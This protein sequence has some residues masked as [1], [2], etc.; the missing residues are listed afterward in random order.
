MILIYFT[1]FQAYRHTSRGT[2][3]SETMAGSR[4]SGQGA[5][6]MKA[7]LWIAWIAVLI[8]LGWNIL[9]PLS[10]DDD[11]TDQEEL[12]P[13]EAPAPLPDVKAPGT[14]CVTQLL[15]G[16]SCGHRPLGR[17]WSTRLLAGLQQ[18]GTRI[19]R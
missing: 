1:L 16:V 2:M 13:F 3:R 19:G 8:L 4:A 18:A 11:Y 9:A 14:P 10:G 5:G 17:D 7:L 6:P 12:T 15:G